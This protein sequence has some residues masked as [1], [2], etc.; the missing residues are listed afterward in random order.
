MLRI[1]VLGPVQVTH[2]GRPVR[3]GPKLVELLAILL[4]EAVPAS[5]VVQLLWDAAPPAGA[6][7]TLRSHISH[8]RRALEA[9]PAEHHPPQAERDPHPALRAES[10]EHHPPQAKPGEP[11][12]QE[13]ALDEPSEPKAALREPFAPESALGERSARK[14][15]RGPRLTEADRRA[16]RALKTGSGVAPASGPAADTPVIR[17]VGS[18]AGAAYC[19]DVPPETLDADRFERWCA[20]G[21]RLVTAGEPALVERGVALLHD[22]LALWRGPAFADL[23]DRPFVRPRAARLEAGRRAARRGYAE[24]L[25]AL[26]RH[27]EA[28]AQLATALADDPYDEAVRRLLALSLYAEQRVD[29]AAEVCREG[30]VLLGERGLDAPELQELQRDILRRLV[31]SPREAADSVK[32]ARPCLLPPDPP[33]FVG[34]AEDL[35]AARRLLLSPADGSPTVL[36]SGLAGVGKTLFA[37]RLAHALRGDFPDGQLYVDMRGYDPDGTP[38]GAG[39]AVRGFLDALAVPP[40]RVPA[41]LEAQTGL[42]RS[43]LADR[44]VLVVVDNV[45]DADQVRPLLPGAAG[46]ATVV[47]SRNQLPG[48]VV[49]EGARP[50][51]LD[52]LTDGESRELVGRRLGAARLAGEPDAVRQIVHAC[53][54]LPLALAI[55]AARAASHPEFTLD[56][57]ARELRGGGGGLDAFAVGGAD[58]RAVFSWSYHGLTPSAAGLFRLL[59]AHPGPEVTVAAA[60]SLAA[61]PPEEVRAAVRELAAA[62]LLVEHL[63]GR[64]ALH[65][66]LRAYAGELADD[67]GRR[68]ALRRVLDHYLHT[69]LAADRLLWPHRDPLAPAA[70]APGVRPEVFADR[71][72]ALAWFTAEHPVLLAAL[73]RAE[74]AGLDGHVWRLAWAAANFLARRGHWRDWVRVGQAAVAAA[75]RQ[76]DR[77]AEAEAHRI[78]GGAHVRLRDFAAAREHYGWALE[79]FGGLG[80]LVGQ[81]FTRR[82]LGWLCEQQGDVRAALGHDLAALELFE[83]A[84]HERGVANTHNS[85]GWCHALLGDHAAAV[86][87]CR[88]SLALLERLGDPVGMAGAWDSLGYAYRQVDPGE[89]LAC[90]RQALGLYRQLGDRMN[91][92]VTLRQLG[93]TQ[94]AGGDSAAARESWRQALDILTDLDHPDADRVRALLAG[95][96]AA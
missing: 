53:G 22:A 36:V 89:A 49:A 2:G 37:V 75:R 74:R 38:L 40:D 64:Y 79:L 85:V 84:G 66:L 96:T 32:L 19:L 46:C 33:Q 80:D 31:P 94:H 10:G 60:A 3:L 55:V 17:T 4:V 26:A 48:L 12:A 91:E 70:T 28:V 78:L 45:R 7:A 39:T 63:P 65:D 24:G 51:R 72:A 92:A 1:S 58:V 54:R 90:Y 86:A 6:R 15:E 34:R 69:A 35:A 82:S 57:L 68:A 73:D 23:A 42:Y 88:R 18:G 93:E 47:V 11:S 62:H 27:A 76:D 61:A 87:H 95:A 21:R 41:T 59:A 67:G 56:A 9:D 83:R 20:D 71:D 43:L 81:G 14:A 5:R 25:A 30:V 29:E 52:L 13:T 77:A 16:R 50:L 44:R 8:L